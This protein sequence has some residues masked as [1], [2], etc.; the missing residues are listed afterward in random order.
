M[1]ALRRELSFANAR[2][3]MRGEGLPSGTVPLQDRTILGLHRDRLE[4]QR[5]LAEWTRE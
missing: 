4:L 2:F 1:A 5:R 3:A